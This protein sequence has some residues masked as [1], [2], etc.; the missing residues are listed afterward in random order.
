MILITGATGLN[1][2]ALV[3]E[4]M[5]RK[6]PVRVLVRDP[7]EATKF[8]NSL[9]EVFVGDMQE[10][11]TL[12]DTL[13]GVEKVALIS[14]ADP[15]KM[16]VTQE[17]FID[18]AKV[19]GV[20]HIIKLS[21]LNADIHS[22][23]RFIRMHGEIEKHLEDSGMAWTHIRPTH[24]MQNYLLNAPTIAAQNAFYYPM[25]H[26]AVAPIDVHD[27]AKVFYETLTAA[28]HE[29]KV[30]ELSGPEAPTMNDIASHLSKTLDRSIR[31]VDVSPE[32]YRRQLVSFGMPEGLADAINELYDERR[33]GTES[34][35]L[36]ATH[37]LFNVKPTTF[38]EF[39][40]QN[41]EAFGGA[42]M[43]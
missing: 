41:I 26:N 27:I 37:G 24:F 11:E 36:L 34:K 3:L 4:F 33:K 38:A 10:A 31:Y 19:A 20:R 32:E 21:C 28:G 25:G 30:Y 13:K 39:L 15:E 5:K 16:A 43:K 2:T 22:P 1:G 42:Q 8:D 7:K 29:N 14:S 6:E 40:G 23:A 12:T 35:V 18:A 9:V 17:S